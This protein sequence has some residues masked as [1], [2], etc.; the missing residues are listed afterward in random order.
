M[1]ARQHGEA[2]NPE[3]VEALMGV[4][5]GWTLIAGHSDKAK[6][7]T[8]TNRRGPSGRARIEKIESNH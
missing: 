3:W 4:P 5:P 6:S 8:K 2:L 1:A 7:S